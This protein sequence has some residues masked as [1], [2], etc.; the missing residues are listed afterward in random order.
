MRIVMSHRA[1]ESMSKGI[2]PSEAAQ[3]AVQALESRTGGKGGIIMV[4][5]GG[6]LGYAFNTPCMAHAYLAEGMTAP[7]VGI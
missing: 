2:G 4:D 7:E 1:V 6:E 5:P 3:Q